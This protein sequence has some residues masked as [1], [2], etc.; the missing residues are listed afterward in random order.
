MRYLFLITFVFTFQISNSQNI[1]GLQAQKDLC[2]M[3]QWVKEVHYNPFLISDSVMFQKAYDYKY[4]LYGQKDSVSLNSFTLDAMQ[5]LAMLNDAHT[6]IN[7]ISKP[8]IPGLKENE[9]WNIPLTFHPNHGIQISTERDATKLI[10]SINGVPVEE[11][12]YQSMMCFGGN[13]NFRRE[14]SQSLFFPI[15]LHLAEIHAPYNVLFSDGSKRII[16]Q[17][18]DINEMLKTFGAK[19]EPYTFQIIQG[20][21][22]LLSYNSCENSKDFKSF[23]STTFKEISEKGLET[24]IID[25]RQNTGGNSILNDMLLAYVTEKPYRQSAGRYW[26]VSAHFK[27]IIQQKRYVKLWGKSFVKKYVEAPNHSILKEDEYALVLP[28]RP[29]DYF[30][31]QS[32]LLIGP[33]TFS[34]ANFLA[35]AVDTYNLMPLAGTPTGENTNDFGEQITLELPQSKL[36]LQ[37]SIAYDIGADGESNRIET[38]DPTVYADTN[39]IQVALQYLSE[40]K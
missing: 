1:S 27:E 33:M 20:N 31:G 18:V 36:E 24:L 11:L 12:Y 16:E 7:L 25:I 10:Q 21:I 9:F 19:K 6:S 38:V 8:L 26:K 40:F 35:D 5:L 2:K 28:K 37:V 3:V 30:S 17:G 34:S 39:V 4:Q 29:R 32:I 23:L 22:G 13:E 14:I 15:Y